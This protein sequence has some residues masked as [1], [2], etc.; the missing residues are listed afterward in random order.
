MVKIQKQSAWTWSTR[1]FLHRETAMCTMRHG[2]G[3]LLFFDL[4]S[5]NGRQHKCD[6]P[7]VG[8]FKWG[9]T[10]GDQLQKVV[11]V[12]LPSHSCADVL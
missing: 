8:N 3:K 6:R 4:G 11:L 1:Q 5:R 10:V 2:L 12:R 7:S 9:L